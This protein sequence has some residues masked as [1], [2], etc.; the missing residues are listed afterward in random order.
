VAFFDVDNTI[1]RGASVFQLGIGLYRR[2]FISV[3][4]IVKAW[5]MNLRYNLFGESASSVSVTKTRSLSAI[6]G[7]SVAEMVGV[8]EQVWDEVLSG[9]VFPGAKHLVDQHLAKGHEVWLISAS[10]TVV[11]DLVA[12]RVGATGGLGTRLEAADG[13]FTGELVGGLLHGPAKAEAALALAAE[14]GVDLPA[15][16]AYGDSANDIPLLDLVGHPCGINPDRR[17]RRYCREHR[18][19]VREF[20]DKRR[21]VRRSI[22]AASRV[23]A[24]WA[25][26]V[27]VQRSVRGFRRRR[28]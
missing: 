1:L 7:K 9:R 23:G 13:S 14:R 24:V 19:P 10:P 26:W 27:V 3:R 20:R 8:A 28:R 21:A 4:D 25:I 22:R 17:L 6:E 15:S 18:W 11:V 16:Y 2:G 5:R 12:A